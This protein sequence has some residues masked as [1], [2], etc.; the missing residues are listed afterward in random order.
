LDKVANQQRKAAAE[1]F[2]TL[3]QY[4]MHV[5]HVD[6]EQPRELPNTEWGSFFSEEIYVIDLKGKKHRYVLLWMGP[7]LNAL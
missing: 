4:D 3:Q 2:D 1:L 6:N 7:N 5:F